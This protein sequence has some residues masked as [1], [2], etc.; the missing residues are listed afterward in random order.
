[1]EGA[2]ANGMVLNPLMYM[3]S[4]PDRIAAAA[5][6]PPG[7]PMQKA[8]SRLLCP[9]PNGCCMHLAPFSHLPLRSQ[10]V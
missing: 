1:M 10:P 8:A 5:S 9:P 4:A 3:R 6:T 7:Q 2:G